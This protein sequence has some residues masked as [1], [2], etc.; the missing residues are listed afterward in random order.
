V[1]TSNLLSKYCSTAHQNKLISEISIKNKNNFSGVC[2]FDTPWIEQ[3]YA[4]LCSNYNAKTESVSNEQINNIEAP[5]YILFF[6]DGAGDF[7]ASYAKSSLS[8]VN[9]D[10]TEGVD[11]G[12]GNANGLSALIRMMHSTSHTLGQNKNEIELHYHSGSGF[13]NIGFST[14]I[15]CA[16]ETKYYLDVLNQLRE[17]KLETKWMVMGYS[18]GG[19]LSI[20]FQN[21]VVYYDINIDL[22]FS[23]DPI[24]Q[25]LFYPTHKLKNTI[26]VRNSH[27]K[28]FVNMFQN[29]DIDSLPG[30]ELR[31]KP[32]EDADE[33]ILLTPQTSR[34]LSQSGSYNHMTIVGSDRV[35]HKTNCEFKKIF[36]PEAT[37]N[38]LE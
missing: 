28:R 30:F 29:S 11:L 8:P 6:F 14:A 19:A 7:N 38:G 25:T 21:S 2:R 31:G 1:S 36:T 24:I 27:T 15:S 9:I 22:A 23:I 3:M 37:C 20:D 33:N 17:K 10:G 34:E 13:K 12:M 18:N 4:T 32:V 5:K 16:K 26:G 35:F